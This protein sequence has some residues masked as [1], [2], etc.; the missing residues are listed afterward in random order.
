M[1]GAA[2][3]QDT[4]E[5]FIAEPQRPL[6]RRM[7]PRQ[8]VF[9]NGLIVLT[10]GATVGCIIVDRSQTGFRLKVLAEFS[11]PDQFGLI[12]LVAG[13]GHDNETIWREM[14]FAGSK[15]LA[16][17]DLHQAAPGRATTLRDIWTAALD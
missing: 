13:V 1:V 17:Y 2:L 4:H 5:R 16:K 10:D 9:L 15:T 12:D 11:L 14:P 7:H 8:E 3:D 6:D